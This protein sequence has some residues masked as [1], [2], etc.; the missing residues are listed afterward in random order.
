MMK[1]LVLSMLMLAA[2][3]AQNPPQQPQQVK[4]D[5]V[6]QLLD[7][8]ADIDSVLPSNTKTRLE[9][10][11][12]KLDVEVL[13]ALQELVSKIN[14]DDK[15]FVKNLATHVTAAAFDNLIDYIIVSKTPEQ[16]IG[17]IQALLDATDEEKSK[18]FE[19]MSEG[20]VN[21]DEMDV[22]KQLKEMEEIKPGDQQLTPKDNE[23]FANELLGLISEDVME[24]LE[25]QPHVLRRIIAVLSEL[26][27]EGQEWV[28]GLLKHATE[29]DSLKFLKFIEQ[30]SPT[31]VDAFLTNVEGMSYEQAIELMKTLYEE[32]VQL[33]SDEIEAVKSTR[34]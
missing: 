11:A 8:L 27:R 20:V 28:K 16:V 19:A 13:R 17:T 25:K 12:E 32:E 5:I 26:S 14:A 2:V 23:R 31:S 9:E 10:A 24:A 22:Q 34:E 21:L 29:A 30:Q 18:M 33:T 15:K 1:L 4:R 6:D 3:A 7:D